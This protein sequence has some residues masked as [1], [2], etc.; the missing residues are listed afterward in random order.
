MPVLI[1]AVVFFLIFLVMGV[2]LFSAMAT[3]HKGHLFSWHWADQPKPLKV[4]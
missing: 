4:K 3:E 2:I 1:I